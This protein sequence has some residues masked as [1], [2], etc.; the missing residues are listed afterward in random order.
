MTSEKRSGSRIDRRRF[1]KATGAGVLATGL[2]GCTGDGGDGGGDGGGG[3]TPSPTLEVD[4]E[5]DISGTSFTY[6]SAV[7]SQSRSARRTMERFINR[8]EQATGATVNVS[9]E[10]YSNILGAKWRQEFSRGNYPV[11]YDSVSRFG[12][13]WVEGDWV[14]PFEEYS[15]QFDSA[16]LDGLEWL[17]EV[18]RDQY[19]N[20]GGRAYEVPLGF[21]A[22]EPF[23]AR[24]DHFE[25]AGLDPSSDYPPTSVEEIVEVG[26]TL[27][28]QGPGQYGFQVHGKADDATDN[29]LPQWTLAKGGAEEGLLVDRDVTDTIVDNDVWIESVTQYVDMFREH[30]LSNPQTPNSGDE[31]VVNWMAQEQV[32]MSQIDF[33]NEPTLVERY[34]DLMENGTI[35]WAPSFGGQS[36]QRCLVTPFTFGITKP[37][38]GANAS[39]YEQKQ[40]AAIQFLKAWMAESFQTELFANIGLLPVRDDVWEVLPERADNSLQ[41]IFTMARESDFGFTAHPQQSQMLYGIFA[42]YVQQAL[43]G[44]ISPEEACRNTARDIRD[45]VDF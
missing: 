8:F 31:D 23:V 39:Q 30:D 17:L 25:Q 1:V 32:S 2:A 28:E 27:Q 18:M 20:Y 15:D 44:E 22:I 14:Y 6:W 40:Q 7:H 5:V 37:P 3:D 38:D 26:T 21:L 11:L 12:G 35:K 34:P 29:I 43:R 42:P 41:S 19:R 45:Q 13:T 36:G 9:W 24:M 33:L 4:D 16:T 10:S